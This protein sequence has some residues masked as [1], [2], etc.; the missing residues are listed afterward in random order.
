MTAQRYAEVRA[1]VIKLLHPS[2]ERAGISVEK[3]DDDTDLVLSGLV[4]SFEFLDL[5]NALEE[6]AGVDIDVGAL[7]GDDFTTL[8]GLVQAA[9]KAGSA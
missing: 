8:I 3:I 5:V 4:D 6:A 7:D 1:L 2:A 9:V